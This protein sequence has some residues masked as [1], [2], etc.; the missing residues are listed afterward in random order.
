MKRVLIIDQDPSVRSFLRLTLSVEGYV[1]ILSGGADEVLETVSRERPDA[2]I[3]GPM[4]SGVDGL[5]SLEKMRA[6][7]VIA[8]V[9]VL[10]EKDDPK[11]RARVE[12]SSA[13]A[14]LVKPVG[15]DQIVA[16]LERT[17]DSVTA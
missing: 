16:H 6:A 15:I 11:T 5:R 3:F 10:S 17:L 4:M 1:P 9:I 2:L 7:G 14:Y 12:A 8:P 13:T